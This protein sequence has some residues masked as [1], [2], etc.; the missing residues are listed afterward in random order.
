MVTKSKVCNHDLNDASLFQA[1]KSVQTSPTVKSLPSFQV[2][3]TLFHLIPHNCVS[4]QVSHRNLGHRSKEIVCI[5]HSSEEESQSN[6]V[7]LMEAENSD[8]WLQTQGIL[9]GTLLQD[10]CGEKNQEKAKCLMNF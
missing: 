1:L 5:Q 3:H 8:Y 4:S 2:P 7:F 10:I 6:E 9:V